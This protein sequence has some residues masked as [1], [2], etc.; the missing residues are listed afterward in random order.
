MGEEK[1]VEQVEQLRHSLLGIEKE[2]ASGSVPVTVLKDFKM[3]VDHARMT[4]WAVLSTAQTDQ[5]KVIA[6]AIARF[7][8]RRMVEM[9]QQT[10]TD[11]KRGEIDQA[12]PEL[13]LFQATLKDTLDQAHRLGP[14]RE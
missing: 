6:S 13:P 9:C 8:L 3:A 10:I 14:A 12:T 1:L 7:R 4:V 11:L 2:I 5:H